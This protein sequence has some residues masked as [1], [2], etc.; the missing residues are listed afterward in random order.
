MCLQW[1]SM[2]YCDMSLGWVM[3]CGNEKKKK[4]NPSKKDGDTEAEGVEREKNNLE[5]WT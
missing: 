4:E 5:K 3:I 1:T 2:Q